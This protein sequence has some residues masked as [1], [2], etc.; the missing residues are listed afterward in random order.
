MEIHDTVLIAASF[1]LFSRYVDGLAT[2]APTD[3]EVYRGIGE[4]TAK[5]G[6]LRPQGEEPINIV[7]T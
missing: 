3:P 5:E 1:C 2:W 7:D 4:K 6:Y